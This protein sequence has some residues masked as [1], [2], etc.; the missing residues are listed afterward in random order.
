MYYTAPQINVY[1]WEPHGR[2]LAGSVPEV[3]EE[4]I[5]EETEETW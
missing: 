2:L 3:E 5:D 1:L 4:L